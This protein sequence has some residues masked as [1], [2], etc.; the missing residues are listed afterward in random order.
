M[1][2][3]PVPLLYLRFSWGL[4]K[5]SNGQKSIQKLCWLLQPRSLNIIVPDGDHP[6]SPISSSEFPQVYFPLSAFPPKSSILIFQQN[7]V[8]HKNWITA[9]SFISTKKILWKCMNQI[10][11]MEENWLFVGKFYL[12]ELHSENGGKWVITFVQ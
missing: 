5:S 2:A 1:R 12:G 9:V 7:L 11:E 10:F 8:R 4:R 3:N 6:F